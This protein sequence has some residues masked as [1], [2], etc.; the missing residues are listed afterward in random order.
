MDTITK[1]IYS[2]EKYK[3]NNVVE[4]ENNCSSDSSNI[5]INDSSDSSYRCKCLQLRIAPLFC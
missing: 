5:D 3:S 4:I 1:S 2:A